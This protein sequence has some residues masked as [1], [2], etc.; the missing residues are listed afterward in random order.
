MIILHL[1]SQD[2]LHYFVLNNSFQTVKLS[3]CGICQQEV[4]G[5]QELRDSDRSSAG[6]MVATEACV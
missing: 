1:R 6:K 5:H 4:D 2:D 3:S